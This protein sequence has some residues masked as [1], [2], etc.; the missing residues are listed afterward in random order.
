M[1][2]THSARCP[3]QG[4]GAERHQF[5]LGMAT[6][7]EEPQTPRP[8]DPGAGHGAGQGRAGSSPAAPGASEPPCPVLRHSSALHLP[9]SAT[10]PKE[11]LEA[12]AASAPGKNHPASSDSC[13]PS[14]PLPSC[15]GHKSQRRGLCDRGTSST[16][17]EGAKL[18]QPNLHSVRLLEPPNLLDLVH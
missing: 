14:L 17:P 2:R 10:C 6:P 9:T 1:S 12:A 16:Y 4:T 13:C 5:T 7:A 15:P 18:G 11:E 3:L 8:S